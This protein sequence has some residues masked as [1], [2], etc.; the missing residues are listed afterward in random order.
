MLKLSVCILVSG[1]PALPCDFAFIA[2]SATVLEAAEAAGFQCFDRSSCPNFC[3]ASVGACFKFLYLISAV[4]DTP[5]SALIKGCDLK[6]ALAFSACCG[7]RLV[8]SRS[9]YLLLHQ[10]P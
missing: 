2:V 8:Y 4:G 10:S 7:S 1:P 3:K 6:I 9:S 5:R